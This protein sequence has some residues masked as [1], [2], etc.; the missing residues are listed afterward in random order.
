[1]DSI[2]NVLSDIYDRQCMIDDLSSKSALVIGVGGVGSWLALDLALIGVGTLIIIDPDVIEASNLN[3]T[4]FKVSQVGM[5]KTLA[6]K[7]LISE[8]RPDA[9]VL[10]IDEHFETTLL[11]KYNVDFI[12]DATDNLATRNLI[13]DFYKTNADITRP[14]YCKCGYDGF[15]GTLSAN[16]FDSGRWGED[17]SYTAVPSFVGTPQVLSALAVI[18]L[19]V[20]KSSI[21]MSYNFNVKKLLTRKK[22]LA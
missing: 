19:V 9:I 8:R 17:G 11:K 16:D 13:D 15:Y 10:T 3:R 5:K 6:S 7:V 1:M 2:N 20:C 18:E 12:F 4:M 14:P 21:P 22:E